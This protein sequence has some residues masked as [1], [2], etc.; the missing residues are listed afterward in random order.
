[1]TKAGKFLTVFVTLFS[2]IFA[3]VAAVNSAAYNDWKAKIAEFSKEKIDAQK[4]ELETLDSETT[5]WEARLKEAKAANTQDLAAIKRRIVVL[6]KQLDQ[7]NAKASELA[8]QISVEG[9]KAQ[10][11]QD[12]SKLRREDAVLVRNQLN[13]LRAQK[14]TAQAE[15]SR[16]KDLLVQAEGTLDRVQR[17]QR[18]L[19]SDGAEVDEAQLKTGY[20]TKVKSGDKTKPAADQ[21]EEE[22]TEEKK[23]AQKKE[24]ESDDA[25][26]DD[27]E[28]K[29]KETETE[30]S[31]D[32]EEPE[33]DKSEADK[34]D[35]EKEAPE[36]DKDAEEDKPSE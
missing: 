28:M 18:L 30:K 9:K 17:R 27:A 14:E 25:E 36:K 32:G 3:G 23:P 15:Q 16:L 5:R 7:L 12:E 1:M 8:V 26:K 35:K 22:A 31:K 4:K 10:A 6:E 29:E 11:I 2:V 21:E 33:A 34:S 20:D 19:E 24:A 13:E